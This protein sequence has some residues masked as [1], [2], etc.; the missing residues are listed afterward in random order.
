MNNNYTNHNR[1]ILNAVAG[2]QQAKWERDG[3]IFKL[4]QAK[5]RVAPMAGITFNS[6]SALSVLS[7]VL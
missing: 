3:R 5:K 1:R 2:E 6:L 7:G 4:K